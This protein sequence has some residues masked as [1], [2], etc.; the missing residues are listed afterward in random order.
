MSLHNFCAALLAFACVGGVSYAKSPAYP[1]NNT[2][3]SFN[4]NWKFARFGLQPDGTSKP[5]PG[6]TQRVFVLSA[7]SYETGTG[8]LPD[9]AMDEDSSTRWCAADGSPNQW[10]SIDLGQMHSLGKIAIDWEAKAA[11]EFVV[12]GSND[13]SNW[14][15]LAPA[16]TGGNASQTKELSLQGKA[17][18]VRVRTTKLPAGKWA[19]IW[20]IR[21]ADENGRPIE[22]A[23]IKS[24]VLSPEQVAFDDT[25]WR[26]LDV[27]HDWGIEGPFRIELTG[28]TGKLPW[29]GIGWYRKHFT[30]PAADVGQ[31][32]FVDFDGAMAYAK[33]WC[34]G[35]YV[36]TWPYGY[37]SFRMDI[38]PFVKFGAE[39][40]IAVRLDTEKWDSRWYPGAGIYRNVWLVKA[41]P[42]HVAH[43]GTF[44]TTPVV[45]DASAGVKME[46]NV[47]N[48]GEA[49]D[50]VAVHTAVYELNNTTNAVGKQVAEMSQAMLVSPQQKN[51]LSGVMEIPNPKR[52]DI[53]SPNR[54]L[55]RTTLSIRGK[56]V[57]TYDTPFG[58]RTLKFSREGFFLN[59][60]RVE[61]QGVCQHHDLGALGGAFN[62]RAL[63][64]QLE[65]L[66]SMGCNSVRT[67]HNP[68]APE[69]L[70][71]ADKMGVLIF[72][73][74]FDAWARG[75][76]A[77]DYNKLFG[78]W[79]E[80]DL[81]AL[82]HRDRNFPSVFMWSI[83]NEVSEQTDVA[84]TKHLADIIRREDPTRPVSNG[85]N[86][87]N[88]GRDSG[89][90]LG[91]DIMGVNYFFGN[92][93]KYDND[94]R[95][96][97]MP[98]M[99]SETSSAISTRGE[100][101]FGKKRENWQITS[102]DTDAVPWGCIP[103][104]QFRTHVKYPHLLGEYV[105]TGFD[106]I[107]EPTPYNSDETNL[108]NFRNDPAKRAELEAELKR[109]QGSKAPS[110]SS[111]F[112]IIDLAGFPKDRYYIYQGHWRPDLP[113]AHLLPHW[114]WPERVGQVT[115]VHLYTSGDEAEIFLN[116]VS[117]GR[118][119]KTPG[120]DFRLVWDDVKYEAGEIKA[121]AYK[122]GKEWATDIVKTTGAPAKV[123]LS[124]DRATIKADGEDLSF[125]TVSI[126]DQS[127]ATVPRTHNLVKFSVE[128][129]GEIVAVDNGDAT[130][131][132]SFQAKERKAFNGLCLVI[133]RS[134]PGQL[135]TFTVKATSDGLTPAQIKIT[136]QK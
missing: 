118:K 21:L 66:Q 3:E 80:K 83:G 76:K 107:G 65:I 73:E 127:G 42:V 71:L 4:S 59:G 57:D 53:T 117:Q 105:W 88:G 44:I 58:I 122:N 120:K 114:N 49:A 104:V 136:G 112:G 96:K 79:H 25:G 82:V 43:W 16:V 38:S 95:Y 8:N 98:T 17:R 92:Q 34:N 12:E 94:P 45:T 28:E 63:E 131:F 103:D 90:V 10:L 62:T 110:R 121:V 113:M 5:E 119:K 29:K 108:L 64:R 130:S 99:G 86:N 2:T 134:K 15:M 33:V 30:I 91:I 75:K 85:Y 18:H 50:K 36:G 52:W 40:V 77:N 56:V 84:L 9:Y 60:R 115:P 68:P 54:Y 27:P 106:Y 48:Q 128:G 24:N 102:Y 93:A 69:L 89:A 51:V 126:A 87:P 125:I 1:H 109:L 97:D 72:D 13:G 7:S 47:E 35:Q 67:S 81:Q 31:R 6:E 101:F 19:S 111:Y 70:E 14:Q 11:Y 46:I 23:K 41:N 22:N 61:L 124:A 116:G 26:S 37:N 123:G 39:N 133:V 132:E 129:P 55:A 32:I 78:G 20:E 135:G 100:Y 74:A